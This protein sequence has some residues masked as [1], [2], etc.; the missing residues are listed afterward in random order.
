MNNSSEVVADGVSKRELK[1]GRKRI[2]EESETK[3][4]LYNLAETQKKGLLRL[5]AVR[6]V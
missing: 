4:S 3:G 2:I 1:A 6:L 5:N